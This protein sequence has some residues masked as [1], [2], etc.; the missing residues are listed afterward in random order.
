[1]TDHLDIPEFLRLNTPEK[2]A[3]WQKA[4]DEWKPTPP[5]QLERK[6][7]EQETV[8]RAV[9]QAEQDEQRRIKAHN[10]IAKL[11]DKQAQKDNVKRGYWD[12]GR[13]RWVSPEEDFARTAARM[14]LTVAERLANCRACAKLDP[15]KTDCIANH[16]R[17][18]LAGLDL[19]KLAEIVAPHKRAPIGVPARR[20]VSSGRPQKTH[21]GRSKARRQRQQSAQI[22][23]PLSL[24]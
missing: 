24:D 22:T 3:A 6:E 5:A 7:S 2:L 14:G 4:R 15:G 12:S 1:M 13:N 10:R 21:Q 20:I 23:L 11:K 16:A 17:N 8:E 18:I 9:F 19:D